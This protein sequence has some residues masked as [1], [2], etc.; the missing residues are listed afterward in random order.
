VLLSARNLRKTRRKNVVALPFSDKYIDRLAERDAVVRAIELL[1]PLPAGYGLLRIGAEG[2]GGYLLP[3]DLDGIEHCFSPGVAQMAEF[4]L[5]LADNFGMKCFLADNSVT[6]PPIDHPRFDF[7]RKHLGMRDDER[8]MR[9]ES[10]I[11]GKLGSATS[12]DLLLQMDIE[13]S[14]FEVIIDTSDEILRRFRIMVIEFHRLQLLFNRDAVHLLTAVFEKI[15]RNFT[16]VHMHPNN[17]SRTYQSGDIE[18]PSVLEIT[19]LR[20]DRVRQQVGALRF[21]HP[22]DRMNAAGRPDIILPRIWYEAGLA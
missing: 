10:W 8:R 20:K 4:E 16:V 14:E 6:G 2:D 21:P 7:V 17:Y 5:A 11:T 12:A 13:G 1:R 3:H 19:F 15:A 22:L 18:I 9:L